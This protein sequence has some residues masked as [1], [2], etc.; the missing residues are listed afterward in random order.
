MLTWDYEKLSIRASLEGSCILNMEGTY[1]AS[2][3][4]KTPPSESGL[5]EESRADHGW[6]STRAEFQWCFS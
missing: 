5:G 3:V 6:P 2:S 1:H 4:V